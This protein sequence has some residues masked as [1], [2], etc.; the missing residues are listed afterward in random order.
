VAAVKG[1][2]MT[3]Q[4]DVR[5]NQITQLGDALAERFFRRASLGLVAADASHNRKC[6]L[7]DFVQK[8]CYK[9]LLMRGKRNCDLTL[10]LALY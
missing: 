9:N 10:R 3:Q 6:N 2:K 8:T 7:L 5:P 1:Q 4:Y